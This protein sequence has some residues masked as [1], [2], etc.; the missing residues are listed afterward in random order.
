MLFAFNINAFAEGD[1]VPE[2]EQVEVTVP[3]P[4]ADPVDEPAS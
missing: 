4:V 1:T 3:V 2:P